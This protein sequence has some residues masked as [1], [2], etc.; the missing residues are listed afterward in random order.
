MRT[1]LDGVFNMTQRLWDGMRQRKFGS[2]IN[3][4]SKNGQESQFAKAN[5]SAAEQVTSA[6]QK[7]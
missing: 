6:L 4:F 3:I 2:L 7:L 1:N 5:Y